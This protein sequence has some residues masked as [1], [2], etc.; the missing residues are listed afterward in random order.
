MPARH[1]II[2]DDNDGVRAY[3][4]RVVVRTYPSLHLV[5]VKDGA[6]ALLAFGQRPAD[7][8]ITNTQM[9][10]LSGIDLV[11]ALRAQQIMIPILMVSAN[12]AVEPA[13][14]AAGATQF[15]LKPLP[16]DLLRR[17]LIGLLAP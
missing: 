17:T 14:L 5:A 3:L 13:A 15:L 11:R 10:I 4:A 6:E 16:L 9:P 1:I 2:A 12:P 7:L 8:L